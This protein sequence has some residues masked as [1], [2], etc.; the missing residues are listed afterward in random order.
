MLSPEF[1]LREYAAQS[2]AAHTIERHLEGAHLLEPQF[3]LPT[4]LRAVFNYVRSYFR[5]PKQLEGSIQIDPVTGLPSGFAGKISFVEPES[6]TTDVMSVDSLLIQGN[7]ALQQL[8]VRL[9]ILLDRLDVAFAESAELEENALRALFR[10]YLDTMHLDALCLKIFLRT[11]IW[12]RITQSG[13]REASHI[14]RTVTIKWD[15]NSLINLVTRR[16]LKND[17]ICAAYNVVPKEVLASVALQFELFYRIFPD[18]VDVGPNKSK[19][20]DWILTRT[21]DGTR[22]PAPREIIHL[23]NAT[24]DAQLREHEIGSH[25]D[26]GDELFSRTALREALPEVSRVKLE[27][28]LYAEYPS[29]RQYIDV[30]RGEKTYQHPESLARIWKVEIEEA[31]NIANQ[32]VDIGFFEPR[33]TKTEPMYWVPFLYRDATEM[34]Q[35]TADE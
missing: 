5:P 19:T 23:L 3:S 18:Q 20:F 13:F 26:S 30:L 1:F 25:D 21:M 15:H 14:T 34:L 17:L 27:Q 11:D 7:A 16:V 31:I 28:T 4:I 22:V 33:G 35:G 12:K 8:G 32:L 9:W 2:D 29:L 24:R 10:V 6:T